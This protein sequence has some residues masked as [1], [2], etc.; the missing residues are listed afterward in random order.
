MRSVLFWLRDAVKSRLLPSAFLRLRAV[1][2]T[3][4]EAVSRFCPFLL[5]QKPSVRPP[6]A[7][8]QTLKKFTSDT[9]PWLASTLIN[10]GAVATRFVSAGICSA[11]V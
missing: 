10:V 4:S 2:A 6:P 8:M 1:K 11:M 7:P 9:L 3:K 5:D